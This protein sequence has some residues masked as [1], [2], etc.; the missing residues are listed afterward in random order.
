LDSIER[1]TDFSGYD[2]I[3]LTGGE[4][5]LYP[6]QVLRVINDIR[7]Q[8]STAKIFMY[9]AKLDNTLNALTLL[10]DLDGIT[11]TLHDENDRPHLRRFENLVETLEWR[12]KS[13]R[14]NVFGDTIGNVRRGWK[15]KRMEWAVDC[16]V[17]SDEDFRRL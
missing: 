10:K 16:P 14:L 12:D 1:C 13:L 4:P 3:M 6:A 2:E 7:K 9:T 8:N 17:P 11:V 15:V 5:M